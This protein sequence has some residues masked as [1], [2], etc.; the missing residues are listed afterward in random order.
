MELL[1]HFIGDLCGTSEQPRATARAAVAQWT[2]AGMP[3]SKLLLGLPIYGY[4]SKSKA[5]KLHG[6]STPG[7]TSFRPHPKSNRAHDIAKVPQGDLSDFWGGQISFQQI[8]GHGALKRNP[9]GSYG[10]ANGY[11][12]GN[13]PV[14]ICTRTD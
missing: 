14:Y 4:V 5:K 13:S 6:S 1:E 12:M 10:G 9:D 11:T 7:M 8:V 2:K 3:A